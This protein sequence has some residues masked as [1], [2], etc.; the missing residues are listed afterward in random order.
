MRNFPEFNTTM[1]SAH[2]K[3]GTVSIR[4][5]YTAFKKETTGELVKGLY[6][7]D[8]YY[9]VSVYFPQFYKHQTHQT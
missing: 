8:F 2:N 3:F 9:Y 6:W 5:V 7:R 4:E 1:L